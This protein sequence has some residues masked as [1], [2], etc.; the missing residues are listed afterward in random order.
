MVIY[1]HTY[2]PARAACRF[3][4]RPY[5]TPSGGVIFK[6]WE[7]TPKTITAGGAV[8]NSTTK[9]KFDPCSIAVPGASGDYLDA[10]VAADWK[11]LHNGANYTFSSWVAPTDFTGSHT[12]F[13]TYDSTVNAVGAMVI[14]LSN[15]SIL[16]QMRGGLGSAP[17]TLLSDAGAYPN[18]A[19]WHNVIGRLD[20]TGTGNAIVY[21]DGVPVKTQAKSADAVSTG[22]PQHTLRIGNIPI[23][24]LP[25]LGYIDGLVLWERLL[26]IGEIFPQTRRFA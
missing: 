5:G 7:T 17:L 16:W 18:D 9:I 2:F 13:S 6:D 1:S 3:Y 23:Y 26:S 14:I 15:R 12:I 10:G 4:L 22:N 24:P 11:F 20:Y 21:V 8:A 19:N 25:M